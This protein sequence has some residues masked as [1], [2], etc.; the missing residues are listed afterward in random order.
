MN[1]AR[2]SKSEVT[3]CPRVCIFSQRH[4]ERLVSRCAEYEFE[5]LICEIDD[6]ELLIPEP[7]LWFPAGQRV[8]NQ[9]VRHFHA[10]FINPG[11]SKLWTNKNYELF[12]AICQFPRD[13]LSLSAFKDWK[14][15]C[16]KSICWLAEI[17][18]GELHKLKGHLKIL[19]Q[20]DYVVIPS[21]GSVQPVKDI[22]GEQCFYIPAGI[23]T[24][25][26]CPYPNPPERSINVYNMGRKSSITH[27]AL[28]K[29]AEQ[30]K[31]FYIYDT[32]ENMKTLLPRDHRILVA[33]I[34]KRSRYFI[35]HSPKIDQQHETCGQNDISY[36]FFEGAASGTVMIG[37]IGENEAFGKHFNWQDAVIPM[38]YDAEN[39]GEIL[40]ELDSQPK[41]LEAARKNN[42]VQCLL[43]HDWVYR[44]RAILNMAGLEPRPAL[45]AREERLKKLAEDI[46]KTL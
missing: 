30:G 2:I 44:W 27:Q 34:A 7:C 41:R 24:V 4:L 36:R 46:R 12:V 6:A 22:I 19:S 3:T 38:P 14:Q 18:A 43:R 20:F 11:I 37:E 29:M 13:L 23:D 10:N 39:V 1:E 5:D 17:W 15:C 33:N 28:L 21:I 42:I 25:R 45:L 8:A 9:I 35:V 16:R 26:F 32:Y 31:I 40:A